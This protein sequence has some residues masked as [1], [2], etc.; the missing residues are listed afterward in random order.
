LVAG[1]KG[2]GIIST[3]KWLLP[4][5]VAKEKKLGGELIAEIY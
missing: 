5:H 3:N 4:A 2:I 1:G